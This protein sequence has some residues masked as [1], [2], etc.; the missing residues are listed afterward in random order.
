MIV[1]RLLFKLEVGKPFETFRELIPEGVTSGLS[2]IGFEFAISSEIGPAMDASD[3]RI[4]G[5]VIGNIDSDAATYRAMRRSGKIDSLIHSVTP[6]IE[7]EKPSNL[8]RSFQS[9]I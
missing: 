7:I 4:I 2:K 3:D 1:H 8:I 9:S 6:Q 5:W